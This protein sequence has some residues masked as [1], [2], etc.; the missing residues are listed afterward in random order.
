MRP[1]GD[2]AGQQ[3]DRSTFAARLHPFGADDTLVIMDEST[4]ALAVKE[5]GSVLDLIAQMASDG[6]AV[7]LISYRLNDI[8]QDC[9][10]IVG[11]QR[12]GALWR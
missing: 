7:I 9:A 10:R 4:A 2:R 5:V 6:I 12:G 8:F 3:L 11:M 1:P